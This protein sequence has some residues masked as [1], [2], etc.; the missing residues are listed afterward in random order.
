[1]SAITVKVEKDFEVKTLNVSA[2]VRYWEDSDVNG[3]EDT[4]G[5]LIPCRK[6]ENWEPKID[7]ETG[8]ITN[9][10]PGTVADVHYKICDAGIYQLA[11]ADGSIVKEVS[12]YV[13]PILCPEGK[14]YGDYIIMKIDATGKISNWKID[15]EF[16]ESN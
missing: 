9:W 6:G 1:M 10:T 7:L 11:A 2:R 4:D 8:V 13:P 15:L 12:G 5:S 14:G 16:F 3:K